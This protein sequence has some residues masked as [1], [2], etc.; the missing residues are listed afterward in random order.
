MSISEKWCVH[1]TGIGNNPPICDQGVVYAGFKTDEGTGFSGQ[2][3]N[4]PCFTE[5]SSLDTCQ[6]R[7]FPTKE[8]LGGHDILIKKMILNMVTARDGIVK[9]IKNDGMWK[10]AAAGVI[11]CPVCEEGTLKYTYAGSYN[12]H[13][14]ASCTTDECVNWME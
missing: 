6:K 5:N 7:Q 10:R 13:I 14:H 4:Y 9:K 12:G 2:F 11:A 3:K 1:Y 8:Q